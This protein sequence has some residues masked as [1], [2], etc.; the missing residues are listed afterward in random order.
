MRDGYAHLLRGAA[1]G[2]PCFTCLEMNE[3]FVEP[4]GLGPQLPVD[5]FM[6]DVESLFETVGDTPF[7]VTYRLASAKTFRRKGYKAFVRKFRGASLCV[8]QDFSSIDVSSSGVNADPV[9]DTWLPRTAYIVERHGKIFNAFIQVPGEYKRWSGYLLE[10][11][12]GRFGKL[13]YSAQ[14]YELPEQFSPTAYFRGIAYEPNVKNIGSWSER[15]RRRLTNWSNHC[16]LGL[17]P[18][19][20]FIRDIYPV[21][22][23]YTSR[24][25]DHALAWEGA[26]IAAGGHTVARNDAI[27]IS[28]FDFDRLN[29]SQDALDRVGLLLSSRPC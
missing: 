12:T 9:S 1:A 24:N 20:G 27:K 15:D 10:L 11:A 21:N 3:M 18:S 8:L 17:K 19:D 4:A 7:R 22:I 5:R 13:F 28:T 6:D 14:V 29:N 25:F 23:M 2:L 16:Y 26:M